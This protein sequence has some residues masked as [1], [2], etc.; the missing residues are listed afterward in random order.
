MKFDKTAL[1]TLVKEC[2]NEMQNSSMVQSRLD[3]DGEEKSSEDFLWASIIDDMSMPSSRLL[4]AVADQFRDN[5][6]ILQAVLL[7]LGDP[8]DEESMSDD[9]KR[10]IRQDLVAKFRQI[11]SEDSKAP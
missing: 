10:Q 7:T 2:I 9:L 4:D 1:K 6:E 11:K 5:P 8:N 3:S